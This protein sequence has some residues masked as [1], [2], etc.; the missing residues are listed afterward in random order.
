MLN[1]IRKKYNIRGE[2][3]SSFLALIPKEKNP[4]TLDRFRPISLCNIGYKVITKVIY[5]CLKEV[6]TSIIPKNQGAFVK[7]R[8]IIYNIIVVQEAI[9]SIT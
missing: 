5:N 9:H 4:S 6:L 2:T 3:N 1:W 7:G 8:H